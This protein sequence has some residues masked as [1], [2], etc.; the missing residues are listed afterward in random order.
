MNA[1]LS[2]AIVMASWVAGLLFLRYFRDTRD[3][4]FLIFALAFWVLSLNWIALAIG[5]PADE[6]QHYYY[7][8]RLV[9]FLLIIWGIIVK[10]RE[11]GARA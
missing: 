1:F 7:I 2:G 3:R 10:N 6:N 5:Q 8:T 11:G 9:A 4:L